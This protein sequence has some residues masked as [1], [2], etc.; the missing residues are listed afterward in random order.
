MQNIG[1]LESAGANARKKVALVRGPLV[2]TVAALN[3]EATP[4]LGLA[5]IAGLLEQRGHLTTIV[6]SI[7]AAL[8]ETWLLED[9]PGYQCQGLRL[10]ETV[11]RIP[12]DAEIIGFS[13][14][15]SGEWPVHR[16]LIRM[17]RARFPD[18]LLVAGGEH[19]TAL[20][21]YSLRDCPELDMIIRGE[22][23]FPILKLV[24]MEDI[25]EGR[26]SVPGLAWLDENG[27]YRESIQVARVKDIDELPR[28]Y[29][30]EGY[31]PSFWQAGKSFGVQTARDMPLL[32]SRGCPFQCTFCSNPKMWT[33]RYTLRGVEEVIDEIK[34]YIDKWD[35]TAVQLY[36]L[37]AITKKSWVV[38][39]C[40]RLKEEKINIKW[41]L[42]SGTRSEAL[43]DETLG[44]LSES[45]CNYLVYAPESGSA[46]TLK[47]IKKK[48]DLETFNKSVISA[49]KAG[50]VL[51]TNLIIGFP[52][53]TRKNVF[54]T[55]R[56]GL[57][58]ASKG[59]D[60]VSINIFSPYP[61]SELFDRLLASGQIELNDA[62]FMRL[63][64]LNSDY[65][66]F[67]PLTF[68]QF[69]S[70]RELAI[71]RIGFM[72][73]NYAIGYLLFPSR[74]IRTIRNIFAKD[75]TATV[76]EHRL[77]DSLA[78]RR[79]RKLAMRNAEGSGETR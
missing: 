54:R 9:F 72:M 5:Y 60:E 61:G 36:D 67:N 41:S 1:G 3:N 7:G 37:T 4:A 39:L 53:E 34:T 74:I 11:R 10:E 42:P 8:N 46:E 28:P 20:P 49:K 2:S 33:T 21:E 40:R 6:D 38:E 32:V 25:E 64:S 65:T 18:A 79:A 47:A 31:L 19:A 13:T 58:L 75:S 71:Y 27:I 44:L 63:T 12:A 14:M 78:R 24:E 57:W 22:G 35:I 69:M 66:H 55:I 48:I 51:R 73:M 15:F 45:G 29:W 52:D 23:E 56:Y 77:K 59:V 16:N 76:F 17:V 68:N 50:L 62:Y 26:E 43:D 70:A 30:P